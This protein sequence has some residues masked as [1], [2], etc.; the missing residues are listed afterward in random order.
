MKVV[1][2]DDEKISLECLEV[3]LKQI[4]DI[5]SI[6]IFDDSEKVIKWCKENKPDVA[7]L[8]IV[9][10]SCIE[11]SGLELAKK[12][13]TLCPNCY[14]I[15]VTAFEK[16]ALNAF[17]LHA[18][19]FLIKPV[20]LGAVETELDNIRKYI[21]IS[22]EEKKVRIQ[23]FGNFE[24]FYDD[25]PL[26]FKHS[27]TRELF[28]YLIHRKGALCSVKELASV[29]FSEISEHK[30]QQSRLRILFADLVHTL[31]EIGFED[32]L[33]KT[34]GYS[35]IVPEEIDCDYFDYIKRESNPEEIFS[36]EYMAQYDWAKDVRNTF[37]N[38][39]N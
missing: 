23:C 28:A 31:K 24:C 14:I 11:K 6:D 21:K 15:F 33:Y 1:A 37:L 16:F 13:K 18:S 34:R 22:N 10:G 17:R 7:F 9:L 35:S 4:K 27:K 25:K 38:R 32:I 36:N 39:N 3:I 12:I 29:L 5:T 26:K 20:T 8:D 2:V 30:I 19:G